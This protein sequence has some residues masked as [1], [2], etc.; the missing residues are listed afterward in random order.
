MYSTVG[1]LSKNDRTTT[2]QAMM[3][4]RLC[5]DICSPREEK[6]GSYLYPT[7][8]YGIMGEKKNKLLHNNCMTFIKET[9]GL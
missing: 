6:R 2:I 3:L 9:R 7:T 4:S 8:S 1:V 5:W